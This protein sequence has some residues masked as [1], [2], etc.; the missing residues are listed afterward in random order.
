MTDDGF[1]VTGVGG[2]FAGVLSQIP[3][4]GTWGTQLWW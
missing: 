2:G 4:P 1:L 3:K